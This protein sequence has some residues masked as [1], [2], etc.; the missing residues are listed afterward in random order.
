[1]HR[2]VCL[3]KDWERKIIPLISISLFSTISK[4]LSLLILVHFIH[5]CFQGSKDRRADRKTGIGGFLNRLSRAVLKPRNAATNVEHNILRR[6]QT[7]DKGK[8]SQLHSDVIDKE[9]CVRQSGDP[10]R[11]SKR[12]GRFRLQKHSVWNRKQINGSDS[13]CFTLTL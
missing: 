9:N 4:L 5:S 8:N 13:I 2:S 6:S 1:M 10:K 11:S 3:Y 7:Q 12:M